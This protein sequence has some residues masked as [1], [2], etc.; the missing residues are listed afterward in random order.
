MVPLLAWLT[1][2][3]FD[4]SKSIDQALENA[5]RLLKYFIPI[6]VERQVATPFEQISRVVAHV[7]DVANLQARLVAFRTYHMIAESKQRF[8]VASLPARLA[9]LR[10]YHKAVE[11]K[12]RFHVTVIIWLL[13]QLGNGEVG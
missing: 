7:I 5:P 10:I 6:N 9:A 12:Q 1:S 13:H 11:M 4:L 8:H 3:V 2:L